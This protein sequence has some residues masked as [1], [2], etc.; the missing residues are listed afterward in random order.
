MAIGRGRARGARAP[1]ASGCETND[2]QGDPVRSA[3]PVVR[4]ETP[5][6]AREHKAR[7]VGRLRADSTQ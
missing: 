4:A 7:Q 1:L 5:K 6:G 2:N 3:G